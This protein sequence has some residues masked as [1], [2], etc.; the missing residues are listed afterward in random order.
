MKR[1]LFLVVMAS[2][3][4][5]PE[6]DAQ[7]NKKEKEAFVWEGLPKLT[8]KKDLDDYLMT[9]DS[10][11]T[12][13]KT[14]KDS[15]TFFKIDTALVDCGGGT[16]CY[17][18][19]IRDD[20]GNVKNF[21]SSLI[22][23]LDWTS[24][25][26]Y[27]VGDALNVNLM[28]PTATIDIASDFSLLSYRKYLKAGPAIASIGTGEI[29]YIT[30]NA[31]KQAKDIK[32]L[33]ARQSDKSNDQSIILPISEEEKGNIDLSKMVA[34]EDYGSESTGEAIEVPAEFQGL[35]DKEI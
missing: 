2:F 25:G 12:R 3:I 13:M 4:F 22:Q 10:V 7:R 21:S 17:Q 28:V 6:M 20:K 31:Q 32:N 23:C 19:T 5:I 11:W 30:K 29:K 34:M 15:V 16:P 9:C 1:I 18:V 14:Y 8:G 26:L 35:L 33:K 27:I 24:T